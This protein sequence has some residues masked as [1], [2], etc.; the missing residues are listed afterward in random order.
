MK[1]FRLLIGTNNPKKKKE[2]A[3]ILGDLPVELA[4]P[5]DT[6]AWCPKFRDSRR[7]RTPSPLGSDARTMATEESRLPSS[8]PT[9]GGK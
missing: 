9:F 6:A 4:I 2:L 1:P 5:A 7:T 8:K 3:V